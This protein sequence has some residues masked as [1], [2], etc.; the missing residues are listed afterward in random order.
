MLVLVH[1]RQPGDKIL[2][3]FCW[4]AQPAEY[5]DDFLACNS[6]CSFQTT[7]MLCHVHSVWFLFWPEEQTK[8]SLI[9]FNIRFY[10]NPVILMISTHDYPSCFIVESAL[11]CWTPLLTA[12]THT[13]FSQHTDCTVL[14]S[15]QLC[16]HTIWTCIKALIAQIVADDL[17][18]F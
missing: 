16:T 10:I 5:I 13:G 15:Y 2:I 14:F 1:F 7:H 8:S 6:R 17:F 4:A 18:F 12:S 9:W 11:A 3:A